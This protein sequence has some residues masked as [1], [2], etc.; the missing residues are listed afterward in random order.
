MQMGMNGIHQ[1]VKLAVKAKLLDPT[2]R[3]ALRSNLLD[4]ILHGV[5]YCYPAIKGDLVRG[6]PT[7]YAAS[8]L[9]SKIVPG[10]D[11]VPVWPHALGQVRGIALLPLAPSVPVMAMAD[12][13]FG[14]IM[15]LIDAIREGRPRESKLAQEELSIRFQD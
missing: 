15:A 13:R 2:R 14:E 8:P 4:F 7:S 12:H 11:P 9:A 10:G 6:V 5:K 1:G 3:R